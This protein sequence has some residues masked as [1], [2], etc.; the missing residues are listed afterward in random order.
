MPAAGARLNA[1]CSSAFKCRISVRAH[2]L[3]FENTVTN[4]IF[5]INEWN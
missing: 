4:T 3:L 2:A 5:M 1:R